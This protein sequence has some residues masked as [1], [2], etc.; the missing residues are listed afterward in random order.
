MRR[1]VP[2][3]PPRRSARC[4]SLPHLPRRDIKN[5]LARTTAPGAH[6][7]NCCD[8]RPTRGRQMQS[9]PRPPG[10]HHD[11]CSDPGRQSVRDARSGSEA[12]S[13]YSVFA[14]L[15]CGGGPETPCVEP[16]AK[17]SCRSPPCDRHWPV[18]HGPRAGPRSPATSMPQTD[19]RS[20]RPHRDGGRPPCCHALDC[21]G[22]RQGSCTIGCR[23]VPQAG[24]AWR[25]ARQPQGPA[26]AHGTRPPA[27]RFSH[28]AA[29]RSHDRPRKHPGRSA[30]ARVRK[31][32]QAHERRRHPSS[33]D[34]PSSP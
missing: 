33:N 1:S 31:L 10:G 12:V 20:A 16:D 34:L 14:A 28:R 23:I 32:L 25:F 2:I 11:P 18:R 17:A 26:T 30:S 6:R 7:V 15:P 3:Y 22:R 29:G 9:I 21:R 8:A 19:P 27:E 4:S 5:G 13:G 24:R